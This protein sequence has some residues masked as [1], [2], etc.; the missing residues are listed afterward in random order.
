MTRILAVASGGGH[1]E[2]LM[3]LRDAFDGPDTLFATTNPDLPKQAGIARAAHLPDCNRDSLLRSVGCLFAALFLVLRFQPQVIVSTGA[4]PGLLCILCGRL[5]GART[6]W[7]DSVAN[8][9]KLSMSGELARR[10]AHVCLTQWPH[11]ARP[12]GPHHAGAVL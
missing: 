11:L 12:D 6:L 7:I 8:A 1:W 4:A 3:R 5:I 2:Q 9:E 10:F